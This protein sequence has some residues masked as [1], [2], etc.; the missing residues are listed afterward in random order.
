MVRLNKAQLNLF[1]TKGDLLSYTGSANV[2][3][4]AGTDGH[5]LVADSAQA[6]GIKWAAAGSFANPLPFGVVGTFTSPTSDFTTWVNQGSRGN[7]DTSSGTAYLEDLGPAGGG[8]NLIGRVKTPSGTP[9]TMTLACTLNGGTV[10]GAN[11]NGGIMLRDNSTGRI[12]GFATRIF[13]STGASDTKLNIWSWSSAT[14]FNAAHLTGDWCLRRDVVMMRV[15]NNGTTLRYQVSQDFFHWTTCFVENISG[16][17]VATIDR[18]G[19]YINGLTLPVSNTA[20]WG[21]IVHHAAL[22]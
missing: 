11:Y 14:A 16:N 18:V 2:V 8:E 5:V 15:V 12:K 19:F 17:Y 20:A 22:T 9:W 4:P 21:M 7:F 1:A 3:V 6:N 13:D 10:A